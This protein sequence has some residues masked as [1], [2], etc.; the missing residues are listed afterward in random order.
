M[1]Q[2]RSYAPQSFKQHIFKQRGLMRLSDASAPHAPL[3]GAYVKVYTKLK[4]GEVR[5][6]KDG[7]TDHR[8]IFDYVNANPARSPLD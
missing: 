1:S 6:Y 8:G 3:S 5:F 7:Y 2:V 4:S